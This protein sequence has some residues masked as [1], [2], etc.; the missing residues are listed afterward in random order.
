MTKRPSGKNPF[1]LGTYIDKF[2]L[3]IRWL[4][5]DFTSGLLNFKGK[6]SVIR[7]WN[8]YAFAFLFVCLLL[9]IAKEF[10]DTDFIQSIILVLGWLWIAIPAVSIGVRRLHD[11]GRKGV[12][13]TVP[14][15]ATLVILALLC[16]D[17]D[18]D[19]SL[20][21]VLGLFI[22]GALAFMSMTPEFA[23]RYFPSRHIPPKDDSQK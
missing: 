7:F 19:F 3:P 16:A 20:Y 11:I 4:Y 18:Y 13:A 5:E 21:A 15:V 9:W 17:D 1:E 12:V 10:V 8:F 2:P 22:I 23:A 6:C 14:P